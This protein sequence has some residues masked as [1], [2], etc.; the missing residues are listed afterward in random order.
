MCIDLTKNDSKTS[1][2]ILEGKLCITHYLLLQQLV[3]RK[4]LKD[5]SFKEYYSYHVKLPRAVYELINPVDDVVYLEHAEKR[6]VLH[7]KSDNLFKRIRIQKSRN[8]HS[9]SYQLTIP[10]KFL[11]GDDYKTG[12]ITIACRVI[13]ADNSDGYVISFEVL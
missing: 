13:A 1:Y 4:K 3:Y 10:T 5:N 9:V 12:A 7:R 11:K 8:D 2:S 6:I